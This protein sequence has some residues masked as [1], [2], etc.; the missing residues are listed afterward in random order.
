MPLKTTLKVR[1]V[2][3]LLDFP[4]LAPEYGSRRIY[5]AVAYLKA[6]ESSA[7]YAEGQGLYVIRATG[8]SA[9]ITKPEGLSAAHVWA[10]NCGGGLTPWSVIDRCRVQW[11]SSDLRLGRRWDSMF[12]DAVRDLLDP[13]LRGGG[14]RLG[15]EGAKLA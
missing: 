12:G 14:G 1:H 6:D 9:S 11:S 13:R 7:S 2:D 15:T 3:H 4:E 5:G 8:S 10:S